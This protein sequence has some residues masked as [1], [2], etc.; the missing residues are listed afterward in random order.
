MNKYWIAALIKTGSKQA[1]GTGYSSISDSEAVWLAEEIAE[2]ARKDRLDWLFKWSR[3]II[4]PDVKAAAF[5]PIV[6]TGNW[7]LGRGRKVD[8]KWDFPQLEPSHSKAWNSYV[9]Y[10]YSPPVEVVAELG[11]N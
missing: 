7:P 10:P 3:S 2:A 11:Y 5:R 8:G 9:V 1:R 4:W 6:Y